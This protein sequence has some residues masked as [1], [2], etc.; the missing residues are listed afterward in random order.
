[1]KNGTIA[2]LLH[3]KPVECT[4]LSTDSRHGKENG[5]L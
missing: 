4:G 5:D 3:L 1:M 2:N